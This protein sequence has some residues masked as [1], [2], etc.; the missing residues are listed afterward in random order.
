VL[1]EEDKASDVALGYW[2]RA[3]DVDGDGEK[4]KCFGTCLIFPTKEKNSLFFL[5]CK[6]Q[7]K[8]KKQ[9]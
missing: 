7:K 9:G 6:K 1:S 3:V 8:N 5:R 2:F 4:K